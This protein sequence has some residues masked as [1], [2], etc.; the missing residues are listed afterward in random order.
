MRL[1]GPDRQVAL[2]KPA[3]LRADQLGDGDEMS[4]RREMVC[5]SG[6][7]AVRSIS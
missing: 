3:V 7:A 4:G 2:E 5:D 6:G 1:R